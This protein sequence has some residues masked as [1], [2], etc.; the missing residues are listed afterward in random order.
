[1]GA[2]ERDR[3]EAERLFLD[4]YAKLFAAVGS[5]AVEATQW[6]VEMPFFR[7]GMTRKFGG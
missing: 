3:P 4:P 1:V 7:D 2:E 6:Q 5:Q